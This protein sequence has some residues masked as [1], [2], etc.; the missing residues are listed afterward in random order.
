MILSSGNSKKDSRESPLL[1]SL[2]QSRRC[3]WSD[4]IETVPGV[5][6]EVEAGAA[7]LAA[8]IGVITGISRPSLPELSIA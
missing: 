4:G 7:A 8:A 2:V 1:R 3:G 6:L 5:W